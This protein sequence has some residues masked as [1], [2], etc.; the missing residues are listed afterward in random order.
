MIVVARGITVVMKNTYM[1]DTVLHWMETAVEGTSS[2]VFGVIAFLVNIPIAF[3]VPSSSG[4]AALVMPILAPLSDFAEVARSIAVTAYQSA[5]G[6]VNYLTPDL[7]RGHGRADAGQGRL[8]PLPAVR[9]PVPGDHARADLRVHRRGERDRVR[10]VVALGGNALL[11]RGQPM[12]IENQRANVAVACEQLAPVAM[13][14]ELLIS[15]GN[16]PQI[17]LLALQEAAYEAVADYPLDVLGAE[18]QGMI[19][20]LVGQEIGNRLPFDKPIATLLTMIEVDPADPAFADPTKPIGPVYTAAEADKLAAAQGWTFR[21]D[22]DAMRRVVPSPRPQRIFE[23]RQIRWLLDQ[24]CVVICAGGGGIPT[25]YGEGRQLHGVEA[26]IDKDHASGLLARDVEA[27]VFAMATDTPAVYLGYGRPS[28]G[29]SRGPT[30]TPCASTPTSSPPGRCAPRSRPPATSPARPAAPRRSAP[31]P[32]SRAWWRAPP[33]PRSRPTRPASSWPTPEPT[34]EDDMAF[35]AHSEVG[36]LHK[37]MV[38]RPGLEHT[39]LTPSNA[40][41]LLFDDVLWVHQAKREHDN[42]VELMRERGVEVFY[43]EELLADALGVDEAREFVKEHILGEREIGVGASARAREWMDESKPADVA[44]FLI[45]GITRSDV[46]RDVG[47][48]WQ[49]VD[50]T[51]MLLPPLPNFLFQRDPSC[52]IFGGVTINPMAKPARKP[53]TV[54][55]QTIYRFHPMFSGGELPV[56]ARRGRGELGTLHRR[57]RRRPAHRQRHGHD[58]DGRAHHAAGG[59]AT[60]PARCSRPRPPPRCW[61]CRCPSRA[62]TCTSTP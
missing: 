12:I 2:A 15:H 51:S 60:S 45:G 30:P 56:L 16:G 26:V 6:F 5:S 44:D 53:E 13:R 54:I 52:W 58:R 22:G 42:F 29:P 47:L 55:E 3:L 24:G 23:I 48:V 62:A 57:G 61:R 39:R 19:G 8:Q 18:T 31:S 35:G 59:P 20:Y 28:S 37:V 46:E 36:K 33:A 43:A 27:D 10:V 17:G 1:T 50:P 40:E 14:D 32:T 21:P 25:A 11:R 7:G 9:H 34:N 49:S 41:E 38:H 4:H